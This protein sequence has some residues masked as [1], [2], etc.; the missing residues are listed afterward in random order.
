MPDEAAMFLGGPDSTPDLKHHVGLSVY[1]P[2]RVDGSADVSG[3]ARRGHALHGA[4]ENVPGIDVTDW[5][6]TDAPQPQW[7][8]QLRVMLSPS[9]AVPLNSSRPFAA[10]RRALEAVGAAGDLD[11]VVAFA[12]HLRTAQS[13]ADLG[14]FE[15]D[16]PDGNRVRCEPHGSAA[17]F[18]VRSVTHPPVTIA[19][20]RT[21]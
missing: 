17:A 15:L 7:L 2:V 20:G 18:T 14:A 10:L 5:G 11:R 9:L 12:C 21:A 1:S 4:L 13:T 3:H 16:L 19:D 6:A 8:V